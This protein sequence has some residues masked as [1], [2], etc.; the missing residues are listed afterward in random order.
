MAL[1]LPAS[2]DGDFVCSQLYRPSAETSERGHSLVSSPMAESCRLAL[3][4]YCSQ[5]F[6]G[7]VVITFA[8]C[9]MD[10]LR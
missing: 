10:H 2:D 3:S 5:K 6:L 1:P 8:W 7:L 9:L 4:V